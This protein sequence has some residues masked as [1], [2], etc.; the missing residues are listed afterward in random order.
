MKAATA[1]D[2]SPKAVRVVIDHEDA[3]PLVPA[4]GRSDRTGVS[5][6]QCRVGRAGG[7]SAGDHR[8]TGVSVARRPG[9]R[10]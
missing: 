6:R 1:V 5:W 9:A 2:G 10:A 7:Y 4:V 8:G 3:E